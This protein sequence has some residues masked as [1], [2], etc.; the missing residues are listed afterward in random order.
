MPLPPLHFVIVLSWILPERP[1]RS[2]HVEAGEAAPNPRMPVKAKVV[3]FRNH[4]KWIYK[5]PRGL[6]L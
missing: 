6:L 4:L 2:A 3:A 5:V 1:L